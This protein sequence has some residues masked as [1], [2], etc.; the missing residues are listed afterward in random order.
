MANLWLSQSRSVPQFH[1]SEATG[2]NFLFFC[3]LWGIFVNQVT[4]F[5]VHLKKHGFQNREFRSMFTMFIEGRNQR[6]L[7]RQTSSN[8]QHQG[9]KLL[10]NATCG[11]CRGSIN[12][13]QTRSVRTLFEKPPKFWNPKVFG[14]HFLVVITF[15]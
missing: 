13:I 1:S 8:I 4:Q 3:D 5:S 11:T 2:R 12:L 7:I 15:Y 10:R 9:N 14:N 6:V